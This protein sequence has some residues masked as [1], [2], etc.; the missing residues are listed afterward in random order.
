MIGGQ[1]IGALLMDWLLPVSGSAIYPQAV[2]GAL[3]TFAAIVGGRAARIS[4]A[5]ILA[6]Q[7]EAP[8][9]P[10]R[11]ISKEAVTLAGML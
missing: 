5:R 3:L 9:G 10:T 6:A 7:P 1:L 11:W 2:F 4:T 8:L